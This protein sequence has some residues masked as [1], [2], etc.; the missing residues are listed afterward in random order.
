V[1]KQYSIEISE[2]LSWN[3]SLNH[4]ALAAIFDATENASGVFF[5]AGAML[6]ITNVTCSCQIRSLTNGQSSHRRGSNGVIQLAVSSK[7]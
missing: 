3:L 2:K 1:I 4:A 5:L 7:D 6:L